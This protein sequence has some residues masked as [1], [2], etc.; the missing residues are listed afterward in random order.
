MKYGSWDANQPTAVDM[1]ERSL[2]VDNITHLVAADALA[3]IFARLLFQ[4][5][6]GCCPSYGRCHLSVE[7]LGL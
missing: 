1:A 4:Q 6:I 5:L 7:L 3:D 2:T